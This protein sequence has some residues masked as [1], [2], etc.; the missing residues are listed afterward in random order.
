MEFTPPTQSDS[1]MTKTVRRRGRPRIESS[2]EGESVTVRRARNRKAQTIYRGRKQAAQKD[3]MSR[4]RQLERTIEGMSSSIEAF[5]TEMMSLNVVQQH[6]KLLI[7]LGTMTTA[8]L[9]LVSEV[10]G[11]GSQCSTDVSPTLGIGRK[12]GKYESRASHGGEMSSTTTHH[13]IS[14]PEQHKID[15]TTSTRRAGSHEERQIIASTLDQSRSSSRDISNADMEQWV[16]RVRESSGPGLPSQLPLKSLAYRLVYSSVATALMALTQ[17]SHST[18]LLSEESRIFGALDYLV[19]GRRRAHLITQCEWLLG[20]GT[21]HLYDCAKLSFIPIESPH[22]VEPYTM[23][24]Q[25]EQLPVL[26]VM[27][28]ESRLVA[29]GARNRDGDLIELEIE[30]P[31]LPKKDM[32]EHF[33]GHWAVGNFDSF[34]ERPPKT[35]TMTIHISVSLLIANLTKFGVC[36]GRGPAFPVRDLGRAIEASIVAARGGEES[37]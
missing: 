16:S 33:L 35:T 19:P 31:P 10:D 36:V 24:V 9:D 21:A 37:D 8:V 18:E 28:V 26:S 11:V 1:S 20:P 6:R 34:N 30:D 4:M 29:L 14:S 2:T 32:R 27:D 3:Q 23:A 25:S 13:P 22:S 7:S 12:D 17:P 15:K 5:A